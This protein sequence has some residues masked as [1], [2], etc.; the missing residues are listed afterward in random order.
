MDSTNNYAMAKVHAGMAS[1]GTIFYAHE[2][3]A[4]KGQ[5]GKSWSSLPGENIIMSAVLEPGFLTVT[6]QFPLSVCVALACHDFYSHYAG[7]VETSIKW[8]NDLYWND[9][10]AGGILIE[11]SFR[12]DKWLASIAGIGININQEQFPGTLRNPV[13]LKQIT[14]KGYD[15]V[16]MA[17]ELGGYLWLRYEE[18]QTMGAEFQL[19]A[20]NARLYKRGQVIFLMWKDIV[21]KTLVKSVGAGG[22]LLTEDTTERQFRFGEA[23]WMI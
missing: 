7:A 22:E 16:E 5:R 10:K 17:R 12:G 3:W 4:G 6:R 15:A 8:P 9:R 11:N 21:V 1:E 19:A 18:L 20:Y 13:S 2:Q 14:G 23:E